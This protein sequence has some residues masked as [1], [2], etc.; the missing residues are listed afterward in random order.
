MTKQDAFEAWTR[1]AGDWSTWAKPVLFA[2]VDPAQ[3]SALSVQIPSMDANWAPA[4]NGSTAIVLDLPGDVGVWTGLALAKIGYAPVP[5]FNAIPEPNRLYPHTEELAFNAGAIVSV[6]PILAAL[7]Q[8]APLLATLPLSPI[9]PPVFLLDSN[10]RV[11]DGFLGPGR[12]DNRSISLPTDFPSA[13]LLLSRGIRQVLLVQQ[14]LTVPQP[15]LS[16][17]LR[18]WQNAGIQILSKSLADAQATQP[19]DIPR[20]SLFRLFFYNMLATFG[21][22]RSF[23]GGFGGYRPD[24]SAAG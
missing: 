24:P 10:R 18:R 23:L 3:A 22:R 7:V 5:L 13:N 20:P 16:H 8:A 17:T 9:A 21:L 11:G 4:A 1:S 14:T 2:H 19:I 6:R 15:D 12:F